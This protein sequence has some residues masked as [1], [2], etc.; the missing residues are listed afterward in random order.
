MAAYDARQISTYDA[1]FTLM[2]ECDLKR[3][4]ECLS[5]KFSISNNPLEDVGLQVSDLKTWDNSYPL[6]P[7][8]VNSLQ[9]ALLLD[10]AARERQAS[11][12]GEQ[13][14]PVNDST[15]GDE[16]A[17]AMAS[18]SLEDPHSK[19][20][21]AKQTKAR[22][23]FNAEYPHRLHITSMEQSLMDMLAIRLLQSIFFDTR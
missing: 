5:T 8:E 6:S 12:D 1:D 2:P 23:P 16:P 20:R 15:G 14:Q 18:L 22:H 19:L 4:L 13:Q 17:T 10:S 11:I 7:T 3:A 9:D 21:P